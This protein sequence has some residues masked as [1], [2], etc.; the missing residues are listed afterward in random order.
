MTLFEI[1]DLTQKLQSST[2]ET[3]KRHIYGR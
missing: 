1:S 3:L 2:N